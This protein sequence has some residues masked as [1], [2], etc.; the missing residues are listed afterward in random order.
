MSIDS[1]IT[2]HVGNPWDIFNLEENV[3]TDKKKEENKYITFQKCIFN[4]PKFAGREKEKLCM[5][6]LRNDHSARSRY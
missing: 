6:C 4:A 2:K 1:Q 3:W 5:L